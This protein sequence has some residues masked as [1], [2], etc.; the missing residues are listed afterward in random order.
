[1]LIAEIFAAA[2]MTMTN[3]DGPWS[4]HGDCDR[5]EKR[6]TSTKD[7]IDDIVSSNGLHPKITKEVAAYITVW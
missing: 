4:D 2:A 6:H 5:S 7:I 3:T 1:M